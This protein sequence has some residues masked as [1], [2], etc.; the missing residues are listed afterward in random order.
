[1]EGY[2]VE[3]EFTMAQQIFVQA[4]SKADAIAKV[5]RGEYDVNDCESNRTLAPRR[6]FKATKV[7]D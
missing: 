5:K 7:G 6:K 2:E 1:M 3:F 4:T